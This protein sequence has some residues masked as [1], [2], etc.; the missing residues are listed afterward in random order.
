M[1]GNGKFLKFG[2]S[3]TTYQI[4]QDI[5]EK[6]KI[7]REKYKDTPNIIYNDGRKYIGDMKSNLRNGFGIL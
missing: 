4:N 3:V 1:F 7:L 2:Q 5:T 6:A